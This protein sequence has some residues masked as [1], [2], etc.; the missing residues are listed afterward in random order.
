MDLSSGMLFIEAFA[1]SLI[2]I[3][4]HQSTLRQY[5]SMSRLQEPCCMQIFGPGTAFLDPHRRDIQTL[6]DFVSCGP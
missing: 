5:S 3:F 4:T 2:R 6:K 1:D